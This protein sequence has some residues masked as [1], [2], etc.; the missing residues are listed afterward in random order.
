MKFI[1]T[2]TLIISASTF[3]KD[4]DV[5]VGYTQNSFTTSPR[6]SALLEDVHVIQNGNAL[7]VNI[8]LSVWLILVVRMHRGSCE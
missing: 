6:C 8:F 4:N 3:T 1:Y 2:P 7:H 5:A